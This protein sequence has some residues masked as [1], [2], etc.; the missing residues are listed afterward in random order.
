MQDPMRLSF[1]EFARH[2]RVVFDTMAK[3]GE[4]VF[5]EKEGVL[6]RLEAENAPEKPDIW[7]DYDLEK[8]RQG[9]RKSAGTLKGVDRDT[10]Q[11]DIQNQRKQDTHGRPA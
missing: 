1:D 5:V 6:F 3:R 9:L 2:L 11:Q 7:A 4:K 8:A 10:L